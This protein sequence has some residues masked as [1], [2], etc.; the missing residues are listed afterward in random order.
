MFFLGL[1]IFGTVSVVVVAAATIGEDSDSV[2]ELVVELDGESKS[3]KSARFN[4]DGLITTGTT[5]DFVDVVV[6]VVAVVV[7]KFLRF[8]V[9][10]I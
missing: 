7:V 5:G 8:I 2:I 3:S 4:E 9:E 6:A 1:T 10:F